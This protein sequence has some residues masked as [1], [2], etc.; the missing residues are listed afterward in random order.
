MNNLGNFK[1]Q[2]KFKIRDYYN[3]TYNDNVKYLCFVFRDEF[4]NISGLDT[5][6]SEFFIPIF[7]DA[8]VIKF[9][10]LLNSH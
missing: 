10:E 9:I 3:V 5:D 4:G 2:I 6:G 1:H 7:E 8:E